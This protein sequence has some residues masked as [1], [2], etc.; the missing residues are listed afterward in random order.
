MDGNV[1]RTLRLRLEKTAENL[2]KNGFDVQIFDHASDVLPAVKQL[3]PAGAV[4]A[5][6]G[7]MSLSE[8]GVIELLRSGDYRYLDRD[9]PGITPEERVD[10]M[11]QALLADVY[12]ASANALLE[13]G[14]IYNVDGNGNRTAATLYGP[15]KVV[16]VVGVNKIVPDFDAAVTRVKKIACPANTMRLSCKTYC[17]EKGE[18][19]SCLN[20]GGIENG[21]GNTS[22]CNDHV[23]IRRNNNPGRVTILLV[24]E[25]LGY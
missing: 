10:C 7:S 22:I 2:R 14:M 23:L 4:V 24:G 21:C 15:K 25:P 16:Y 19:V 20:N 18:C 12:L 5:H 1:S 11:R 3:I 13:S 6:G 17:A 8:C 9:R